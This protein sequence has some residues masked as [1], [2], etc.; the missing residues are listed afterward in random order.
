MH[1]HFRAGITARLGGEEFAVLLHGLDT[2]QHY[3]NWIIFV[4]ILPYQRCQKVILKYLLPLV[5]LIVKTI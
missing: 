1:N 3:N 4:E 2:D 5:L